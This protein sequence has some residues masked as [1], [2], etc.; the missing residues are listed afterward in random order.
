MNQKH[1]EKESLASWINL[2]QNFFKLALVSNPLRGIS[3][4]FN[5][6]PEGEVYWGKIK[7]LEP[8]FSQWQD[9]KDPKGH[10]VLLYKVSNILTKLEYPV[11]Q[12][13]SQ[14]LIIYHMVQG[15][16]LGG[17]I[18]VSGFS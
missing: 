7:S 3:R 4:F 2:C 6:G 13:K 15:G 14:Y 8:C 17:V 18:Y 10:T 9:T 16:L 5:R 1:K 12:Q 11:A